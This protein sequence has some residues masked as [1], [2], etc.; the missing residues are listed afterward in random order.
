MNITP[1]KLIEIQKVLRRGTNVKTVDSSTG[2]CQIYIFDG[3]SE[4]ECHIH[5]CELNPR[6]PGTKDRPK[7]QGFM[8]WIN[9]NTKVEHEAC[10]YMGAAELTVKAGIL[11]NKFIRV[12]TDPVT[13]ERTEVF[14]E[15]AKF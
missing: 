5:H 6:C 11:V 1:E 9:S 8:R 14:I 12:K 13:Q 10:P 15:P 2:E 4:E 7:C 3:F